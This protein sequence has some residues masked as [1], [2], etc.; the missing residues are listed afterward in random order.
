MLLL[1][2]AVVVL[3]RVPNPHNAG[4]TV[5]SYFDRPLPWPGG[6][7]LI[8]G[9]R[10]GSAEMTA[11]AGPSHCGWSSATFLTMG[12]PPGTGTLSAAHSRQFIRDPAGQV[13]HDSL[14]GTWARNPI[15]P[16][17][18]EDTG[19][20]YGA[21]KLYFAPSDQDRYAYLIAPDDSERWPRSDPQ[22]GCL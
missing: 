16:A 14:L 3:N 12:W 15:L 6:P 2:I 7:W 18:A 17:D 5:G 19:F 21:I 9:R 10:V 22:T 8:D 11:S 4:R 13:P 20:R 1:L